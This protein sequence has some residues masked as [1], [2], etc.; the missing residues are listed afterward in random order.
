MRKSSVFSLCYH[1]LFALSLSVVVAIA[2][3]WPLLLFFVVIQKTNETVKMSVMQVMHNY[4]QLLQYL[5]WPFTTKLKMDNFSTSI[6][7]AEHFY[8]CKLLFQLALFVFIIG[9]IIHWYFKHE[10]HLRRL[11]LNKTAALI[12]ILLPIAVLPLALTNFDSFFASFHQII[13]HNNNWLFNPDTDPIINV[14]TEGFF[15][16]CFAVGGI[17]YELYFAHH[18]MSR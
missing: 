15:A 11:R 18:L 13:F 4:N 10:H 6:S 17:V 5:L 9:L 16:A 3:S 14:L 8:E 12:F 2:V 1:F 7:A